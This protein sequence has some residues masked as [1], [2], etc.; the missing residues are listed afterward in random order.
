[1]TY[2]EVALLYMFY[3]ASQEDTHFHQ[4]FE[5]S[6]VPRMGFLADGYECERRVFQ[7]HPVVPLA[8]VNETGRAGKHL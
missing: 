4:A 3:K 7:G 5:E 6:K 8:D 1:M 2:S